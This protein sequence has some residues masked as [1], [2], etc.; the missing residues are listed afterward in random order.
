MT[1]WWLCTWDDCINLFNLVWMNWKSNWLLRDVE[2]VCRGHTKDNFR[3]LSTRKI[4]MTIMNYLEL[5]PKKLFEDKFD[6]FSIQKLFDNNFDRLLL[7]KAL[8][9][10]FSLIF[11]QKKLLNAI[12]DRF[13]SGKAL[14]TIFYRLLIRNSSL[15][16]IL[17]ITIFYRSCRSFIW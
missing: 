13:S 3:W 7:E 1:V 5:H 4:W 17:W 2:S 14:K 6:L 12:F 16:T 8:E 11:N 9:R 10:Q 15:K